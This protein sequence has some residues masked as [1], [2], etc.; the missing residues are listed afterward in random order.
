MSLCLLFSLEKTYIRVD[1]W[2]QQFLQWCC[3][4]CNMI[5]FQNSLTPDSLRTLALILWDV[6]EIKEIHILCSSFPPS[7]SLHALSFSFSF[8]L[9]P[10]TFLFS[11]N[12]YVYVGDGYFRAGT[13]F[14]YRDRQQIFQALC[15]VWSLSQTLNCVVA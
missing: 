5:S 15:A 1:G 9:Y 13:L 2:P 12:K 10:S 8:F 7:P 6:G 14:F 11:F 3:W 4:C